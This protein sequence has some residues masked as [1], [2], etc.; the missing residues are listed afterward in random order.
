MTVPLTAEEMV[1]FMKLWA[2]IAPCVFLI[3]GIIMGTRC[4]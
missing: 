1:L 4:K 3:L 2:A